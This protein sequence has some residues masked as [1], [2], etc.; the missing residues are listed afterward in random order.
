MDSKTTKCPLISSPSFS[1]FYFNNPKF[2]IMLIPMLKCLEAGGYHGI[3][4]HLHDQSSLS[5][6]IPGLTIGQHQ[7]L[8]VSPHTRRPDPEGIKAA[9]CHALNK[10]DRLLHDNAMEG[11]PIREKLD[12]LRPQFTSSF[13]FDEDSD[14]VHG[15]LVSFRW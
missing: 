8:L 14:P 4:L 11:T 1:S 7:L 6:I 5:H 9:G 3:A 2:M 15:I 10:P 12:V 13:L